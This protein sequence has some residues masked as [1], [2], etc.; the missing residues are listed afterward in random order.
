[1]LECVFNGFH[2]ANNQDPGAPY[3]SNKFTRTCAT[4]Q[5]VYDMQVENEKQLSLLN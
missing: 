2:P 3:S 4:M 1:M 5:A